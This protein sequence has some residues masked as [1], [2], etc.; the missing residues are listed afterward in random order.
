ME[1][2]EYSYFLFFIYFFASIKVFFLTVIN[3]L[4]D[5]FNLWAAILSLFSELNFQS[6]IAMCHSFPRLNIC[7]FEDLS[8]CSYSYVMSY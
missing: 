8:S 2:Y 3:Y 4:A 5:W 7:M 1:H 6:I